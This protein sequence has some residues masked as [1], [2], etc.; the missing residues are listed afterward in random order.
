MSLCEFEV[1][2]ANKFQ[3]T[4]R[5]IEKSSLKI[6]KNEKNPAPVFKVSKLQAYVTTPGS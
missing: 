5:Y 3:D 2:L 1:S 4:Q 6:K